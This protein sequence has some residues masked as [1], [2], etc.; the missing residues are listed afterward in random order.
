MVL[1][2]T[3]ADKARSEAAAAGFESL[4][5]AF[6]EFINQPQARSLWQSF[7]SSRRPA[8][9]AHLRSRF[10]EAGQGG[11]EHLKKAFHL[12]ERDI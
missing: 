8:R 11:E 5:S 1:T 12:S 10:K 2:T 7:L 3:T 4:E 9:E 6:V